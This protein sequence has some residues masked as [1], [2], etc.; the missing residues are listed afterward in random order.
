MVVLSLEKIGDGARA[1]PNVL[2]GEGI[3]KDI[4]TKRKDPS[5]MV[6]GMA[7]GTQSMIEH[8]VSAVAGVIIEPMK[9]AK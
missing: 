7:Y 5:N 6:T 8:V 9:G 1:T 4:T 3:P 2:M